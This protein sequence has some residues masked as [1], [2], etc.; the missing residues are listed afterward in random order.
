MMDLDLSLS[1]PDDIISFS[2]VWRSSYGH[3]STKMCLPLNFALLHMAYFLHRLRC[4][5]VLF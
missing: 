1:E 5:S 2:S 4:G 3:L